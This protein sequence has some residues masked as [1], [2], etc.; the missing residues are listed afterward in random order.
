[1]KLRIA[2][3]VALIVSAGAWSIGQQ[4]VPGRGQAPAAPGRGQAPPAAQRPN[5]VLIM[6]D[7]LGYGDLS[8]YGA[9]DIKTPIIDGIGREGIRLTDFY[10]NGVLCSPTR[11]GLITG[12]YQQR[13]AI[14]NALGGEGTAVGLTVTGRSFPQL[15]KNNGYATALVGKWHLGGKPEFYPRA[16]GFEYFYGF[17]GSHDDYYHHNRGPMMPDLWENENKIEEDGYLTD[18]ITDKSIKFI[19]RSAAANRPFFVDV[20]YNA[21]HWPYQPPNK[22]SPAPGTGAQQRPEQDNTT[23]RADYAAMVES[24]DQGVGRILATLDRLN[25]T[26]NTIVIFTNDNGGEW[27]SSN[28]PLFNRKWTVWEGGIRVPFLAK[29]PGRIPPG[30]VSDQVGITMDITASVLAATNTPVPAETKLD[31][32]N[33]FPIL[34][35]QAPEVERTLYWRTNIGNRTMRAIRSGDWKIVVDSNHL[36]VFNLR[37]DIGEREDLTNTRQDVARRLR[38]MLTQWEGSVDAEAAAN[39]PEFV[40]QVTLAPGFVGR[41][42]AAARGRGPGAAGGAEAP[43]GRGAAAPA[44]TPTPPARGN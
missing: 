21:P 8:S 19:E 20:A 37:T 30:R 11:A 35:G 32:I 10:A 28:H 4:A 15:L 29:W 22:P 1:M 13:Y 41:G 2:A 36:F 25:L 18:L 39:F 16:H 44:Q 24:V 26:G 40:A 34:Q 3:V 43:A 33:L 38:P 23:T 9:T 27:I 7:D 14:E 42:A 17:V 6:S 12:R 5:V 31:G